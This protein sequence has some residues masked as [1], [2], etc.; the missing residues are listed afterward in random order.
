MPW[1]VQPDKEEEDEE[2]RGQKQTCTRQNTWPVGLNQTLGG[3]ACWRKNVKTNRT[4]RITIISRPCGNTCYCIWQAQPNT[5]RGKD[6][7]ESIE[8][9]QATRHDTN[10]CIKK[11]HYKR[12]ED[13]EFKYT[14][15]S[16][17]AV[18]TRFMT[19]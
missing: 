8:T 10:L 13:L 2:G 15:L 19:R 16:D 9:K 5:A 14:T 17:E 6:S 12:Q 4:K 1:R 18:K 3:A 11:K 7:N